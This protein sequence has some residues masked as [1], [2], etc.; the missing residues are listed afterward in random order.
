MNLSKQQLRNILNSFSYLFLILPS[1]AS[2]HVGYIVGDDTMQGMYGGFVDMLTRASDDQNG[3]IIIA[4][5]FLSLL[6]FYLILTKFSFK[7]SGVRNFMEGCFSRC[8]ESLSDIPWILRLSV[9]I[10]LIGAGT[11]TVLISP[12]IEVT[13]AVA[14]TEMILGFMLLAGVAITWVS[15]ISIIFFLFGLLS[16]LYLIGNLDFVA[17]ALGILIF[18]NPRPGIDYL[19]G[20]HRG[21]NLKKYISGYPRFVSSVFGLTLIFL[22]IYEKILYAKASVLVFDDLPFVRAGIM[23]AD[24]FTIF[25]LLTELMLGLIFLFGINVRFF[26]AFTIVFLTLSFFYFQES[27]F[28]HVTIFGTLSVLFLTNGKSISNER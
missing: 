13:S 8:R 24:S 21:L 6:G 7:Y 14:L 12:I 11:N 17:L 5:S 23:S 18:N 26:S 2:A 19:F 25:V 15:V 28:S 4:L 1:I 3:I 22:A 9:G 16:N 10:A 27:V 20:W